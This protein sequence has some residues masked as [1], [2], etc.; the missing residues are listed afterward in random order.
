MRTARGTCIDF[1]IL[2]SLHQVLIDSLVGNFR[3][4]RHVWYAHLLLFDAFLPVGPRRSTCFDDLLLAF[5]AENFLQVSKVGWLAFLGAR[6]S[7]RAITLAIVVD[8]YCWKEQRPPTER[9][10]SILRVE[11]NLKQRHL[12]RNMVDQAHASY[13]AGSKVNS[14]MWATS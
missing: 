8:A 7:S 4:Q 10:G 3:K 13:R 5:L 14:I 9:L 2:P 6:K 1:A 11:H 12:F